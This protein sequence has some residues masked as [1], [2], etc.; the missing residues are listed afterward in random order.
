MYFPA[1]PISDPAKYRTLPRRSHLYLGETVQF[2][3]VLRSRDGATSAG[4]TTTKTGIGSNSHISS[5]WRELVGS[6]S[7]VASVCPNE[8][9]QQRSTQFQP[10]FQ[11]SC[12][13]DGGEE[14]PD[15]G[16]FDAAD[17]SV[18][19]RER[20]RTFRNC[21]PLLIH[22][23]SASEGRQY[24]RAPVQVQLIKWMNDLS[25][26]RLG[27]LYKGTW[28]HWTLNI[29]VIT[30]SQLTCVFCCFCFCV[31]IIGPLP[32]S[33]SSLIGRTRDIQSLS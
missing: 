17:A 27:N 25:L 18:R 6:L 9:R 21:K 32:V 28:R 11:S 33:G 16:D 30:I 1:V 4:S 26:S 15:E 24:R 23:S 13:D 10:D 22:N 31:F 12:S 5:A 7:A 19:R 14:E 2:L 8:S 3:L 29:T 20:S